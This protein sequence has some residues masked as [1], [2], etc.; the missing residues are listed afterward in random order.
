MVLCV[1]PTFNLP[2][3][4]GANV[5]QMVLVQE[6]GCEVLTQTPIRPWRG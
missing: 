3:V 1:E 5:E 2:E 6:D 4:G